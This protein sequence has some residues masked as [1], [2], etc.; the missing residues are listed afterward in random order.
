MTKILV[1][2]A[3]SSSVK[4][5]LYNYPNQVICKGLCE[6]IFVDG[7]FTIEI[8]DQKQKLDIKMNSHKDAIEVIL[9]NL[10]SNKLINNYDEIQIIGHRVVQGGSVYQE[11]TLITDEVIEKLN[12]L[13]KLA[14]LHNPGAVNVMKIFRTLCPKAKNVAVFDTSFHQTMPDKNFIYP[15]PYAWYEDHSVRKYGMHGTSSRFIV[16]KLKEE[17]NLKHGNIINCHLG[18]GASITAIKNW[19]G[20]NTSMGLTPLAGIMMGT[21]SGD[22]DPAI[23]EYMAKAT[24]KDVFELTNILNKESGLHGVSGISSDMRDV[25][26]ASA[27]GN[28]RAEL[29]L[30]IYVSK[31][32]NYISMYLNDLENKT[33]VIVFTAGIGEN[34]SLIRER[35]IQ[36]LHMIKVDIN[37]EI[38][39]ARSA[40]MRKI[41][42]TDSEVAVYVVPTDEEIMIA[43]DAYKISNSNN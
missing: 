43:E 14:P 12:D 28:K 40:D 23:L 24:N 34:A 11:S 30:N 5:Q 6:R 4:F 32:V 13:S 33:E 39:N 41:S 3:G 17:L 16:K 1:I 15:V 36:N 10:K 22:I 18:N 8:N 2:N 26:A 25:I 38:N 42:T 20:F 21:R 9:N 37:S 27:K 19:K 7:A 35:V 29:A 31:I